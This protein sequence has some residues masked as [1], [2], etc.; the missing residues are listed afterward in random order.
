MNAQPA[1]SDTHNPGIKVAVPGEG[2]GP[3]SVALEANGL[4]FL[5]GQ[6][7]FAPDSGAV[8]PGGI[9]AET[10]ATLEAIERLLERAGLNIESLVSLTCYLADINEWPAMNKAFIEFFGARRPPTRTAIEAAALPFGLRVE[11][12][13]IAART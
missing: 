2:K 13:A 7:G 4:V 12:T 11:I 8:V 6:G 5:S 9:D 10:R 1:S 3:Y